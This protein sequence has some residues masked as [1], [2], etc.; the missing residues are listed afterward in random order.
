MIINFK[1]DYI[2]FNKYVDIEYYRDNVYF[3]TSLAKFNDD[4]Y[5]YAV[6][7]MDPPVKPVI[8]GND[9]TCIDPINI[10]TN[11]WWNK[12]AYYPGGTLFFAGNT[13]YNNLKLCNINV[14]DNYGYPY[15]E[16]GKK[17]GPGMD[18][19]LF[20]YE[21]K[22]YLYD[23][24]F[25]QVINITYNPTTN[26]IFLLNMIDIC[27]SKLIGKN[28]SPISIDI[29]NYE[30]KFFDWFYNNGIIIRYQSNT[31]RRSC[32]IKLIPS[33]HSVNGEGSHFTQ[34]INDVKTFGVNYGVMPKISFGTPTVKIGIGLYLG[35][36]HIKIHSDEEKYKYKP[37]SN[38][39]LF[40]SNL[41]YDMRSIYGDRYIIHKGTGRPPNCFGYIYMMYFYIYDEINNTFTMSDAYL[42]INLNIKQEINYKF[43][44]IFPMGLVIDQR[45]V[46]ISCGEGD[47]YSV[48]LTFD[49]DDIYNLCRHNIYDINFISFQYYILAYYNNIGYMGTSLSDIVISNKLI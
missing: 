47:Y 1:Y 25:R 26:T 38:I 2:D 49:L 46:I 43:S 20:N 27:F 14:G 19:R 31:N 21:N 35:V 41:Y 11:Y 3:N 15:R 34:N 22:I 29:K 12:W 10:G 16:F 48:I 39:E 28:F 33:R 24:E 13:L 7:Y 6:R 40:R 45:K 44:L 8:P 30:T 5:L 4:T 32:G 18:I 23:G 17:S 9:K 37:N 36:G 42:P